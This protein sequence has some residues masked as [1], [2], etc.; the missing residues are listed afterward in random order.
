MLPSW[1]G[2]LL[3]ALVSWGLW[4]VFAKLVG[5][6]L[7]AM[8]SQ[9]LS[10]V[11]IAPVVLYFAL[12]D[13]GS[14]PSGGRL[15]V[16]LPLAAGVVSCL[17]NLPYYG[18]LSR[19]AKAATVVPLTSLYPVV[20]ILLA[21]PLLDESMTSRQAAGVV[22]SLAAIYLFNVPAKGEFWS[23]WL[24]PVLLAIVLWGVAGYL[25]KLSTNYTSGEK[26]AL[27]FHAAFVAMGVGMALFISWPRGAAWSTWLLAAALGLSMALGNAAILLAYADGGPAS[28]VTPLA[29]LYPLVS[30]PISLAALGER[31]GRRETLGIVLALVAVYLLA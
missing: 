14:S 2:W 9:M 19:G 4:A 1:F 13:A 21:I 7:P 28:V 20:T 16:L 23:P 12:D 11:G 26:S 25:Q 30:I 22:L 5:N 15:G 6:R 24:P 8:Q 3:L 29:G 31:I 17:G 10:T 18:V 27:W